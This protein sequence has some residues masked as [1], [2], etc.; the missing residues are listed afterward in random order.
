MQFVSDIRQ[1]SSTNKTDHYNRTEMLLKVALNTILLRLKVKIPNT[2]CLHNVV[3]ND[4][5]WLGYEKA[6]NLY[7]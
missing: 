7:D 4:V 3:E 6:N 1:V 2:I 5:P